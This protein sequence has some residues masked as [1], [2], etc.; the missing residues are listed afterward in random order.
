MAQ[1]KGHF[2][3]AFPNPSEWAMIFALAESQALSVYILHVDL[4]KMSH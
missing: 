2:C 3:E 4:I 1:L